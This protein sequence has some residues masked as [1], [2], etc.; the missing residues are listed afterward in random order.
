M[1][2]KSFSKFIN[3]SIIAKSI[4]STGTHV[5]FMPGRFQ[6][7]H[8]GHIEALRR[9]ADLLG[10]PVIPIQILSK[11][12]SFPENLLSKMGKDVVANHDFIEDFYIYPSSYGKTVIPF[13]VRYLREFGYEPIGFGA[14]SDRISSYKPQVDYILGD[15]TDTEVIKTFKMELVDQR[16]I[17]G[18]SGTKVREALKNKDKGSFEEMVPDYLIKYYDQLIKH[19]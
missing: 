17:D 10:Y 12:A 7:F 11:N 16:E 6:P 19:I 3:E 13:F 14:G 15:K 9:T 18:P 1:K 2:L 8:L 5:S 4:I